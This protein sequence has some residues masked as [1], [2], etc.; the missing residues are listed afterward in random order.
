M[1]QIIGLIGGFP[2]HYKGYDMIVENSLL[3]YH[4]NPYSICKFRRYQGRMGGCNYTP[5]CKE[6]QHWMLTDKQYFEKINNMRKEIGR[7]P[8]D[9]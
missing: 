6:I 5:Y 2:I 4:F 8:F 1:F 9:L 7:L 3:C